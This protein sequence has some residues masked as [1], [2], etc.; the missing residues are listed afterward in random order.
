MSGSWCHTRVSQNGSWVCPS[1]GKLLEGDTIKFFC[2]ICHRPQVDRTHKQ[3]VLTIAAALPASL[4]LWLSKH[5]RAGRFGRVKPRG[6]QA[7]LS[8]KQTP[9]VTQA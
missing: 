2:S 8:D 3:R 6:E 1:P 9:S 4:P 7:E 5:S